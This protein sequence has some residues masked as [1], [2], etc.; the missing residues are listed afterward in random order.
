VE[1]AT[2]IQQWW[3]FHKTRR[4]KA[5]SQDR[6]VF[7]RN[8]SDKEDCRYWYELMGECYI[9]E[10]MDGDAI[11]YQKTHGIGSIIFELR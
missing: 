1:A 10:I 6:A 3:R 8:L 7:P 9:H 2:R 11:T 4:R 5:E